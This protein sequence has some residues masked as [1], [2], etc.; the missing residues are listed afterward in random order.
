MTNVD[1]RAAI[2]RVIDAMYVA[3]SGPA[4][5]RDWAKSASCFHPSGRQI[6]TGMSDDGK[7]WMKIMDTD[8]YQRDTQAFFDR[9]DFYETEIKRRIDVLG[10]IAHAW[11][12]YEGR[13]DQHSA[14][15]ERRGINSIQLYK[16]E[17]GDWKIVSMMWDNERPGVT[18]E[19]F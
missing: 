14:E 13:V 2:G 19:P 4:G 18:H 3:I 11:S 16:D 15:P 1:E 12:L 8:E 5:P 6:R 9:S 7:P 17:E 10:N